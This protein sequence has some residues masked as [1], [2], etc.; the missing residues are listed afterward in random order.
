MPIGSSEERRY[1]SGQMWLAVIVPFLNEEAYLGVLL[2]SLVAQTRP[3]DELLLVDDGSSDRS[4]ELAGAFAA[5]HPWARAL[6]RPPRPP[7]RDRLAAAHE[8]A[9]FNWGVE[10][11][12]LDWEVVAKLDADLRLS[13]D[14]FAE[15]ERHLE[16]DPGLGIAG[17][18]L[19]VEEP[20]GEPVRERC[21]ADHV[22]GATKFYRRAC[23]EQVI[24]LPQSLG[25]DTVDEVKARMH[26]WRT[27]S[28]AMPA[29]DPVHL[30]PTASY[31]GAMRGFRRAGIGTYAYGAHPVWMIGSGLRRIAQ[32][33]PVIGMLNYFAGWI[34]AAVRRVP[35]A[36]PE[37]RRFVHR[38][39]LSRLR[40]L[41]FAGRQR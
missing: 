27:R 20:D 31:N 16:Q 36:D 41:A 18:Y 13:P 37:V 28:F 34:Q 25:W 24:P 7:E 2:G 26:G 39:Q 21:P 5:E 10:Q 29:G 23:Y 6:R 14:L 8:L 19:S 30:R 22:R 15:L 4:G 12:E 40:R 9:A 32:R 35:R 11:L 17:A 3:P 33:P 38:E 1:A